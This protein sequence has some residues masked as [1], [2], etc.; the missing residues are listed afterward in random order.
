DRV[1]HFG[2]LAP[3]EARR[4]LDD[5]DASAEAAVHLR[6]LEP[7][8]A[9][10]DD[11]KMLW[12]EVDVHHAGARQVAYAVEPIERRDCRSPAGVDEDLGRLEQRAV[13]A[14]R[15]RT[16]EAA[17]AGDELHVRRVPHPV[18]HAFVGL[19]NDAVLA[20]LDARH[21]DAD[22]SPDHD[23]EVAAAAR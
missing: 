9:A 17:V 18:R 11:D 20:R 22:R 12:E 15:M 16:L 2:I 1:R 4:H 3:D 6:E 21:V 13:D 8:V 5:G 10:A 7:D 23:A 14:Y 19:A